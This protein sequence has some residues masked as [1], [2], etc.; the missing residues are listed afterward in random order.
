[1]PIFLTQDQVYRLL[2]REM[3]PGDVYPDGP[4]TAYFSTAD[5]FAFA[6]RVGDAYANLAKIYRNYSPVSA[7]TNLSDHEFLNFGYTLDSSLSLEERRARV[8]AKI[9]LRRRTTPTDLL[10]TVYTILN[11]NI[12]VEIVEWGTGTQ[13]WMLDVSQLDIDTILNEFNGLER[14]GPNLC[15]LDAAD[16]GMTQDEFTRLQNQA[17]TYEVRIYGYTLT[18]DERARLDQVLN[19]A[20]PARSRHIIVDGLDPN[21]SIGGSN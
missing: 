14:T 11:S 20:E 16:Y 12:L 1:M 6:G 21:D 8:L 19:E 13:G 2:Q 5:Q 7:D 10:L 18:A 15:Q 3:P 4:A 17:Y 9:R